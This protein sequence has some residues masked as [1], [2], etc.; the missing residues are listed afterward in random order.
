MYALISHE[1]MA[2][3]PNHLNGSI[4]LS[5]KAAH[6]AAVGGEPVG[7][8]DREVAFVF[9]DIESSTELSQQNAEAFKQV[10]SW[11][12]TAA[13]ARPVCGLTRLLAVC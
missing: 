6:G 12:A 8:S 9:T 10:G 4:V 7:S 13:A 2:P 1:D 11:L 3:G 5:S